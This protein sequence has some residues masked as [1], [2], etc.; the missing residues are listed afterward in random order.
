[1]AHT[2]ANRSK[3]SACLAF[4]LQCFPAG[5]FVL[6]GPSTIQY[7][8]SIEFCNRMEMIGLLCDFHQT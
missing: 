4:E 7:V 1:M 5:F 8:D 3:E 6:A 2:C